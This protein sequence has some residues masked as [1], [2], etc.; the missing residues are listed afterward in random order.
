LTGLPNAPFFLRGAETAEPSLRIAPDPDYQQFGNYLAF[1]RDHGNS[2]G[3]R[4]VA[5]GE[6]FAVYNTMGRSVRVTSNAI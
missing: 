6:L 1:T 2:C 4:D 5:P 3:A